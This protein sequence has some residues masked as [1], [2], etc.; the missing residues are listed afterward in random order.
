MQELSFPGAPLDFG[1]FTIA[2]VRGVGSLGTD[3]IT[4]HDIRGGGTP[5]FVQWNS[6]GNVMLYGYIDAASVQYKI[7]RYRFSTPWDLSTMIG[8]NGI[9]RAG[10]NG[11]SP[12]STVFGTST[13]GGGISDMQ[14]NPDGNI[15]VMYNNNTASIGQWWRF[16][17][18]NGNVQTLTYGGN[19]KT[20]G[21][22]GKV[23]LLTAGYA[24][25][26]EAIS[27]PTNIN[28]GITV[29]SD[30]K[31][32]V[33]NCAAGYMYKWTS[34]TPWDFNTANVSNNMVGQG[35]FSVPI[36]LDSTPYGLRVQ[37]NGSNL[38]VTGTANNILI[39]YRLTT[40]YDV[41][42]AVF[43]QT[44]SCLPQTLVVD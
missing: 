31:V 9:I 32:W 30:G 22:D 44:V 8:A 33:L 38:Y 4:S 7:A 39:H 27:I 25:A 23:Q 2:S 26:H 17:I 5:M 11:S 28:R 3:T 6:Y 1:N 34:T 36:S 42:T 40:P 15:I 37:D 13:T 41:N 16:D 43:V 21:T 12:H 18:P 24:P 35:K 10:T 20:F 19:T 14:M 29:S